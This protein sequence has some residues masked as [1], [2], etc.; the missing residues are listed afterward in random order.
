M[1]CQN[2]KKSETI[3]RKTIIELPTLIEAVKSSKNGTELEIVLSKWISLISK[4][5]RFRCFWNDEMESI[6]PLP[7]AFFIFIPLSKL[8]NHPVT[9]ASH[10]YLSLE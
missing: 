8:L 7:R 1:P 2:R 10:Y 9:A 4:T 5:P 6:L 3:N